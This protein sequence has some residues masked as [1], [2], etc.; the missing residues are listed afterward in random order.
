MSIT[1]QIIIDLSCQVLIEVI[2]ERMLQM[3]IL[4]IKR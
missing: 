3:I 1:I 2:R 4:E